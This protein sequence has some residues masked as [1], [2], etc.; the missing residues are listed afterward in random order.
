MVK[1]YACRNSGNR[2]SDSLRIQQNTF[3]SL[4]PVC[5]SY[6][7]SNW[8][9]ASQRCLRKLSLTSILHAIYKQEMYQGNTYCVQNIMVYFAHLIKPWLI[10]FSNCWKVGCIN[11]FWI[12]E[13]R[14]LERKSYLPKTNSLLHSAACIYF[15][16]YICSVASTLIFRECATWEWSDVLN[17]SSA[18][19][20]DGSLMG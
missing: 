18:G 14:F 10:F 3:L 6:I 8:R 12:G 15:F 16:Y 1:E 7:L 17:L 13:A 19:E 20:K 5:Q 4:R 9:S 2:E 11:Y